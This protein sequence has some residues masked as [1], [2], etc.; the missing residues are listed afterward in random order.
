MKQQIDWILVS[1]VSYTFSPFY[2]FLDDKTKK[3]LLFW[4]FFIH[5]FI[6]W[7]FLILA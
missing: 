7:P 6:L 2:I 3:S 4:S 5:L 1:V